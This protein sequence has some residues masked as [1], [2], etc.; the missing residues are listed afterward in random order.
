VGVDGTP[1]A[2]DFDTLEFK[3]QVK[4]ERSRGADKDEGNLHRGTQHTNG[5]LFALI[6][7]HS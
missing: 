1:A 4:G 5:L 2:T 3:L 6:Y 7:I